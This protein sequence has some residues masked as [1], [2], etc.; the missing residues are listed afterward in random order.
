MARLLL[1]ALQPLF[2]LVLQYPPY[3]TEERVRSVT[4]PNKDCA[5]DYAYC[6]SSVRKGAVNK[7]HFNL[8]N[9]TKNYL[10]TFLI[11]INLD[12]N[13]R[14]SREGHKPLHL[15]MNPKCLVDVILCAWPP[16]YTKSLARKQYSNAVI[17]TRYPNTVIWLVRDKKNPNAAIWLVRGTCTYSNEA[18]FSDAGNIP[19]YSLTYE[20]KLKNETP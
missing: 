17:G 2:G 20:K 3:P 7:T 5:G 6:H 1:S 19:L 11:P 13:R 10:L 14:G 12:L 9:Y 4:R 8:K 18:I 16:S 15:K